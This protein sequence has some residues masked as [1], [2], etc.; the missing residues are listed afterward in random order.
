MGVTEKQL[1]RYKKLAQEQ[2][3]EIRRLRQERDA[4]V[5]EARWAKMFP[6][7]PDR[8]PPAI[9]R[10]VPPMNWPP[11]NIKDLQKIS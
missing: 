9:E 2:A 11:R 6:S 1:T 7:Y 4:L 3:E 10:Q 5:E 8:L